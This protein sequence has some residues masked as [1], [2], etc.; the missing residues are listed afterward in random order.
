ML[1]NVIAYGI[2]PG[3]VVMLYNVIACGI[4][5]GSAVMQQPV[6]F[7]LVLVPCQGSQ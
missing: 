1:Y 4:R 2:R 7:A 6:A 5:L 3:S